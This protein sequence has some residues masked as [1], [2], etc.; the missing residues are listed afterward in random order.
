MQLAQRKWTEELGFVKT[1][2]ERKQQEL[3]IAIK[4]AEEHIESR[5][6]K[7]SDEQKND[8]EHVIN[9]EVEIVVLVLSLCIFQ[10]LKYFASIE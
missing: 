3:T 4:S 10:K 8:M 2:M 6:C 7:I 5:T 1:Q 9:K